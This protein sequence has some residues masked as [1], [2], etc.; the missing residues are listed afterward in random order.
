ME[1]QKILYFNKS[2]LNLHIILV[3]SKIDNKPIDRKKKTKM[4]WILPLP[5]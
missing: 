4:F 2:N 1:S 3:F 5:S